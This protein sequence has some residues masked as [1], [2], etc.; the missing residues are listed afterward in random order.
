MWLARATHRGSRAGTGAVM[1]I[2]SWA[3]RQEAY[4]WRCFRC[5][6]RNGLNAHHC[7]RCEAHLPAPGADAW[8]AAWNAL[9][10]PPAIL[11]AHHS[12]PHMPLPERP[13]EKPPAEASSP[14]TDRPPLVDD[15]PRRTIE[16]V[17]LDID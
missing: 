1:R 9:T 16:V 8:N 7:W 3:D 4:L 12:P 14:P 5:G 17:D 11:A 15:A 13:P 6:T 10:L 2:R